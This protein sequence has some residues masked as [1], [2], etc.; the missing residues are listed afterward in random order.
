MQAT[1]VIRKN[2]TE[3]IGN[4]TIEMIYVKGGTFK[5]GSN[6]GENKEKPIH[7]V[8]ISDFYIGRTPNPC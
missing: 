2:Y 1:S 8:N 5:M 4:T 3:K 7:E 6:D